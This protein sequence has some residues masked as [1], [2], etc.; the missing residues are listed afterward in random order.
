MSLVSR[1]RT[2]QVA[3]KSTLECPFCADTVEK[4]ENRFACFPRHYAFF[5][6]VIQS[7]TIGTYRKRLTNDGV[8]R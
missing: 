7:T 5:S 3:Q 4:L 6:E 2:F 1:K 8:A